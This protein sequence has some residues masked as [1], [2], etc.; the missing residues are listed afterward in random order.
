MRPTQLLAESDM[1]LLSIPLPLLQSLESGET[2][3]FLGAGVGHHL[4]RE[5]AHMPDGAQLAAELAVHFALDTGGDTDLP[6]VAQY[7]E[8][9]R[10][11]P[12][13]DAFIRERLSDFTPD[14]AF[15]DLTRYRWRA[16][17]TTNYDDGIIAAYDKNPNPPQ[18]PVPISSTGQI[19]HCDSR[20]NVPVYYLHGC[21][22]PGIENDILITQD[23]F[24][25]FRDS[26]AMLFNILKEQF[27]QSSLLYIGYSNRDMNWK[28]VLDEVQRE[29]SPS[30]TPLS[31]RV[32]VDKQSIADELL[33]KRN[34]NSIHCDL[35]D[36]TQS[37]LAQL[38]PESISSDVIKRLGESIPAEFKSDFESNPAPVVRFLNSW[39]SVSLVHFGYPSNVQDFL[40]GNP[41]EW[42]T[43]GQDHYFTRDV[44]ETLL[45]ELLDFATNTTSRESMVVLGHAGAGTTTLLMALAARLVKEGVKHVYFLR[46]GARLTDG[47]VVFASQRAGD[48]KALFFIDNA[49]I[50]KD[51][52]RNL[53]QQAASL[54]LN[55]MLILGARLNEWQ[56]SAIQLKLNKER[57]VF[58]LS[59]DE[60]PRLID[61][62]ERHDALGVLRDLPQEARI[63]KIRER[64]LSDLLVTM[65]EATEGRSFDLIIRDE[66]DKLPDQ[67]K[68]LYTFVCCFYQNQHYLRDSLLARLMGLDIAQMYRETNAATEGVVHYDLV[69]EANETYGARARHR[70]IAKIVWEMCG[71]QAQRE[72]IL[73]DA[74]KQLNLQYQWDR[75]AFDTFVRSDELVDVFGTLDKKIAY[76]DAA[77][78]KQPDNPYVRQHYARMLNRE[79]KSSTALSVINEALRLNPELRVLYHTKGLIL[80]HL[81]MAAQ[82]REVGVRYL[83]QAVDA[84]ETSIVKGSREDYGYVSMANL[85]LEWARGSI[86]PEETVEYVNK[87]E[88]AIGRGLRR[89]RTHD[90]LWIESAKIEQFLGDESARVEALERASSAS[91]SSTIAA[92]LLSRHYRRNGR[93][94]DAAKLLQPFVDG[95]SDEFRIFIEFAKANVALGVSYATAAAQ[96]R[97]CALSGM[98]DP[99]YVATLGGMLFLAQ[100]YSTA[101]TTFDEGTKR[102]F[103]FEERH[104]IFYR[105]RGVDGN[106]LRRNGKVA[107]V[108]GNF[109]MIAIERVGL[110]IYCPRLRFENLTLADGLEVEFDLCFNA[111]GPIAD[112]VTATGGATDDPTPR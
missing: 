74:M 57:R 8:L 94:G 77:I 69:D 86:D 111:R 10:G 100:D 39:D 52:V 104:H 53:I 19:R 80:S 83:H 13:L 29:F 92:L 60:I 49:T 31:Y 110:P 22:V 89:A 36:F 78:N 5:G 30:S 45:S 81:C 25:R 32:I 101:K 33:A 97:V 12:A 35:R 103:S 40:R 27:A 41:A 87:A 58:S 42:S 93:A 37:L 23:D 28:I 109:A 76:F 67:A 9:K 71:S 46:R 21:V 102:S 50:E 26:R 38:D 2:V 56:E 79:G 24:L 1:P 59:N 66:Y 62:L 51:R 98:G 55:G 107:A 18:T 64:N 99:R 43:I 75:D 70:T 7:V 4:F 63:N 48:A 11:R 96:L 3:L 54:R 34:V 68:L 16:I 73:L 106:R 20:L 6:E 61:L 14:E 44:E 82:S 72:Q 91:P 15:I 65:R 84:L 90:R 88:E 105:P 17:F 47:D 85:Y 95:D 108:R 112:N